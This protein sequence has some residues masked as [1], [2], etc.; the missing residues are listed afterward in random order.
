MATHAYS[1]ASPQHSNSSA[2]HPGRPL[3]VCCELWSAF[4]QSSQHPL[5]ATGIT[6]TTSIKGTNWHKPPRHIPDGMPAGSH[7]SVVRAVKIYH[8]LQTRKRA[9]NARTAQQS[10]RC[11]QALPHMHRVPRPPWPTKSDTGTLH[12]GCPHGS[13]LSSAHPIT[14]WGVWAGRL[15]NSPRPQPDLSE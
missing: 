15:R 11:Q 2:L 13:L 7:S 1:A 4:T 9:I 12:A 5:R 8:E 10:C 14:S 3:S 6:I